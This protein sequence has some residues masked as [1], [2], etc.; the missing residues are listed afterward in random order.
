M[1]PQPP[2]FGVYVHAPWCKVRCPYCAFNVYPDR[3]ARWQDWADGVR[4]EWALRAADCPDP[5]HSVYFGGG[6][7]SLAPPALLAGILAALP[8]TPDVEVTVEVNPGTASEGRLAELIDAGVNRLSLG[9]QT[10]STRHARILNRG[11]SVREAR[12]LLRHVAALPLRSWSADLIFALPG[13]TLAELDQDLDALLAAQP[14]H[15]S[16]YGLTFEPGTPLTRALERGRLV[17]ADEDTWRAMFDRIRL[18]LAEAGYCAYEVSNHA[19]PGHRSR[20]NEAVWRGGAYAGLGP[21][22]HGLLPDGARTENHASV[23]AWLADPLGA[24]AH[25]T[26]A[27]A[28]TDHVLTRLR[29]CDGIDGDALLDATG[30]A[31][32]PDAVGRLVAAELLEIR[33]ARVALTHEGM[34]V[35]D[36]VVRHLAATLRPRGGPEGRAGT[37]QVPP[38]S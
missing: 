34:A 9:I 2:P 35:A 4:R 13:Q 33:G 19:L 5:A 31:L 20:H 14:P 10:F 18:R 23:E 38:P 6:T 7:P 22:A 24:R 15:V 32:D 16:L 25:P 27:Q 36:G 11:H 12:D 21:G 30:H 3:D 1:P 28:A 17:E 8:V 29:H 26:A 37:P